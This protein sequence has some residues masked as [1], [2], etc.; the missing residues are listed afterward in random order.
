MVLTYHVQAGALSYELLHLEGGVIP[1]CDKKI[2]LA[3][4]S[5]ITLWPW[6]TKMGCCGSN[7][8]GPHA[9]QVP[10]ML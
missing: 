2:L 3:Q 6:G 8:G 1:G 10:Y 9:K 4:H 5:V 7:P